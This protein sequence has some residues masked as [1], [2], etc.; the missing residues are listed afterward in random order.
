M[1]IPNRKK[2]DLRAGR[3]R[4]VP[5]LLVFISLLAGG[6]AMVGPD[7]EKVRPEVGKNWTAQMEKGLGASRPD[8][9]VLAEWW[10][11]LDDP[12]LTA[13]EEKA[14][15]GNLDLQTSL[16][17]LRQARL[18]RGISESGLYPTL[19]ASGAAQKQRGSESLQTGAGGEEEEYYLARFDSSWELDLFGGI[20]R[21]IEAAGAEIEAGRADVRDVLVSLMAEVAVN[22]IEVRTYQQRLDITRANI[23]TQEKTYA[24]NKSRYE[25]GLIDELAEQQSLRNLEATRAQIPRLKSGLRAAKNRLAV[26]LGQAPGS[27]DEL[28]AGDKA[29]PQVPPSVAVGIPAEA[30]R[31]RPDIRRAERQLAAQTARIGVATAELYPKFRLSGTIGLEA[32]ESNFLDAQSRFWGIGPGVSWNIFR[33]GAL[34]L[35]ID[36]QTERQKEA[37]LFY[38]STILQ[39]LQEVENAL[40]AYAKEQLREE[41]LEKAVTAARRTEFLARDRYNTGLTDFYNV[42]EAQRALLELE[43]QLTLSRAEVASNLA[44]LY[45]A[46]GGGWEYYGNLLGQAQQPEATGNVQK[47]EW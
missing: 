35:N 45:K 29:I 37:L 47:W 41:S 46:L 31:R 28:L 27:I 42:L 36:L 17:R 43:D 22:Y 30:M 20:R 32:L 11:V 40:T 24:L 19:N 4:F 23:R 34:R 21:S 14:V 10:R 1:T 25:A 16:S 5:W 18:I 39:S 6:C 7:Y 13:L 26:L 15:Q 8:R 9:D 12:V 44:R 3:M 33:G 2:R 38:K